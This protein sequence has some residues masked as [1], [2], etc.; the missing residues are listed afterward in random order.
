LGGGTRNPG[1]TELLLNIKKDLPV[2]LV[3]YH[4]S[5]IPQESLDLGLPRIGGCICADGAF[6]SH[7]AALFE[8]YADDPDNYGTLTYTQDQ[9]SDFS[10]SAHRAGLQVAIHCEGD[11]AIEQV[12]GPMKGLRDFKRNDHRHRIERFEIPTENQI[13][14]II[15]QDHACHKPLSSGLFFQM[16]G[17][18]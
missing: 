6:E 18:I 14:R 1:A 12:L 15:R 7:T 13:E 4:Q 5:M 9:M 17:E 8:P 11:R 2:K 10:L 16:R 3:L